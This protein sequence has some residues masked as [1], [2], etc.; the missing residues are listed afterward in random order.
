M[1]SERDPV[2]GDDGQAKGEEGAWRSLTGIQVLDLSGNLA[3]PYCGQ[4]LADMGARVIKV[5]R[6]GQGD[7]A[8]A[9]APPAWRGDGTLFLAANRGK[10]SLA[11]EL[12]GAEAGRIL[13]GLVSRSQVVIQSFR[14]EVARRFGLVE[15]T[16]RP[17]FP[18]VIL[19][20]LT[21]FDPQGPLG[22]RPGYD[23]L[24]Q[25]YTG[26]M[27]VTG[28]E[29]GEPSRAGTSLVDMGAGMWAAL[30]VLAALRKLEMTG[31]GSHVRVSLEDTGLAWM[32]YHLMGVEACGAVPRAMGS[33][34]GMI[35]PYRAFPTRDGHLMIAA[36]T[37][38][39]F[40][41]CC[42][43][44]ELPEMGKDPRFQT[45]ADRVEHREILEDLLT[46]A[47]LGYARSD[48]EERLTRVGVPCAPIRDAGE[49]A[50][51]PLVRGGAFRP[52][53]H[54]AIEGYRGVA[55]P[56]VI[57][58]A[59]ASPNSPPPRVGEHSRS[60]LE[61]LGLTGEEIEGLVDQGIVAM[62]HPPPDGKDPSS[63]REPGVEE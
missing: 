22:H 25:A 31:E 16:F 35:A 47:T 46:E 61:E 10:E 48:L 15:E 42:Q 45:N 32:A 28:P 18:G 29:G 21:A 50:R 20:S 7:P 36:G 49:V 3:G 27:S 4:I 24:I 19:C 56:P 1:G 54:P 5:E 8:R 17:R 55:P 44:L 14:P 11:L 59:R 58:D 60:L 37:D 62:A 63:G 2:D 40:R 57:D 9:W 13:D 12:G 39:L 26:I 34:L 23:P 6:P 51:D 38:A 53:P 41:R 33:G 43:A 30:G 52:E